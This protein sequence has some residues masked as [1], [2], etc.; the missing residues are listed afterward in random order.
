M[1]GTLR[2][3]ERLAPG[4]ER[5]PHIFDDDFVSGVVFGKQL[6][7]VLNSNGSVGNL[8]FCVSRYYPV[9]ERLIRFA[10]L[11]AMADRPALHHDDRM[12][13]VSTRGRGGQSKH[14]ARF[15]DLK[16]L[17]KTEGGNMMG[18]TT[19]AVAWSGYFEK[20][21]HQAGIHPPILPAGA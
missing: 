20:L 7:H 9:I 15:C 5:R 18:A 8:H 19:V 10:A 13:S 12:M 1:L 16:Y 3:H 21:L 4:G 11:R 17:L 14:E 6:V 2:Q